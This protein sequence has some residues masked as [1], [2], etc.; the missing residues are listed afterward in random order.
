MF[1]DGVSIGSPPDEYNIQGQ[2]WGLP[3]FVPWKASRR[4]ICAIHPDL[5][6]A[7][8]HAGGLRIDHVMGLV[9]FVSGFRKGQVPP[10]GLTFVIPSTNL[11]AILA[12]ESQRA[13][14]YIV[15]EDLGTVEENARKQLAGAASFLIVYSGSRAIHQPNILNWHLRR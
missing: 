9:P 2:N 5:R 10:P 13:K 6:G 15:G 7:L 11:L 1:A 3:P 12:L 8:R 14:A 4:R